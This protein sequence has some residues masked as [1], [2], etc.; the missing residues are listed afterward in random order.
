MTVPELL[1]RLD[2]EARPFLVRLLPAR[3][4]IAY[5]SWARQVALRLLTESKCP[6]AVVPPESAAIVLWGIRFRTPLF[7]AAGMFKHGEGYELAYRQGAGAYLAGTTTSLPRM[8]ERP[9]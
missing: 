3:A 8:G 4:T 5:Y 2:A 6:T 9:P 7:N 1:A